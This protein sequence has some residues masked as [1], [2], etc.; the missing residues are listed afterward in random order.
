MLV[1]VSTQ[2]SSLSD[3]ARKMNRAL[4]E[5]R[6]RGVKN[7]IQF[8]ENIINHEI[9]VNG[10]ATVNF[11]QDYPE[12]FEIKSGLDRGTRVLSFLGEISLNGNPD[13]KNPDRNRRLEKPLIPEYDHNAPY[14]RG[15]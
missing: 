14:P 4:R 9:F 2:G 6:I 12:L 13:V 15:T 11:I 5:F 1:K 3:A 8:L 7:N 10:K